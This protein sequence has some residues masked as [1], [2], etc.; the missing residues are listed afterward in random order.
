M[1]V[2]RLDPSRIIPLQN[3]D[4]TSS[5]ARLNHWFIRKAMSSEHCAQIEMKTTEWVSRG[6][7][8]QT[9]RMAISRIP[10]VQTQFLPNSFD[11]CHSQLEKR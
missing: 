6:T 9:N 4:K 1:F 2:A 11:H 5:S 10:L 3:V 7:I 8:R